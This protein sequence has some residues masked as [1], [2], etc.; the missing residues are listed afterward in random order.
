MRTRNPWL[1]TGL[2]CAAAAVFAAGPLVAGSDF[3]LSTTQPGF[4]SGQV[5]ELDVSV[6]PIYLGGHA[7]LYRTVQGQSEF[8]MSF[9]LAAPDFT[10][11]AAVPSDPALVGQM[12]TYQYQA[13]APDGMPIDWSKGAHRPIVE[14]DL[15]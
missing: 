9:L 15:E 10:V 7:N 11:E 14:P 8:V 5:A 6:D 2:L 3:E 1:L 12:L 4:A 13:F